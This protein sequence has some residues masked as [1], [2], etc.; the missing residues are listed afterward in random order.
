M[1][2]RCARVAPWPIDCGFA[3]ASVVKVRTTW[4]VPAGGCA[5][6]E[7]EARR[8]TSG[9]TYRIPQARKLQLRLCIGEN[10]KA[11]ERRQ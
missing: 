1:A 11:S 4:E 6:S 5:T 7:K 3:R 8:G 2:Q 9:A 10:D